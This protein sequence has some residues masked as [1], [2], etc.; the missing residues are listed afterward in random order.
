MLNVGESYLFA[1]LENGSIAIWDLESRNEPAGFIE[2]NLQDSSSQ[3]QFL[4]VFPHNDN[5]SIQVTY[6]SHLNP[7]I[8]RVTF[9]DSNNDIKSRNVLTRFLEDDRSPQSKV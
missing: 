5:Q 2:L 3:S 9:L 1:L 7:K 6:G 4:S 8:E